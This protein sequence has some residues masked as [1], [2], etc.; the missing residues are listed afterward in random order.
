MDNVLIDDRRIHVDFCQS[1]TK[2]WPKNKKQQKL[3]PKTSGEMREPRRPND[4]VP[5]FREGRDYY[6]DFSK[7]YGIV[8]KQTETRQREDPPLRESQPERK[9]EI[10][11]EPLRDVQPEARREQPPTEQ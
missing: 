3:P 5:K 9:R 10:Q 6:G 11:P 2:L 4:L 1:V 7:N 8:T